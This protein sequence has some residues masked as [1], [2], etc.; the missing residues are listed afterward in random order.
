MFD[1]VFQ[2]REIN[3]PFRKLLDITSYLMN[4]FFKIAV[5]R[6]VILSTKNFPDGP[7]IYHFDPALSGLCFTSD[8][9]A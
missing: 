6:N 9:G 3:C 2:D 4:M 1:I 5:G 8:L 7:R